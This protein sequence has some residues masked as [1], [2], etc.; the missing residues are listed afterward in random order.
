M[1][2]TRKTTDWLGREKEEHFDD[3]GDKVGETRFKEDW[4]GN[5]V[6]EHFNSQ[7]EKIAETRAGQDSLG[8]DRAEHFDVNHDRIGTS[9][10]E[11]DFTGNAIQRHYDKSGQRVGETRWKED[12][13]GRSI[14]QHEGEYFKTRS[15]NDGSNAAGNRYSNDHGSSPPQQPVKSSAFGKLIFVAIVML[16]IIVFALLRNEAVPGINAVRPVHVAERSPSPPSTPQIPIIRIRKIGGVIFSY[17]EQKWGGS[18]FGT[19]GIPYPDV[20]LQ[21]WSGLVSGY[22]VVNWKG[23][24]S[25]DQ[26]GL[27]LTISD[28]RIP[29]SSPTL[30]NYYS[31][32]GIGYDV[33]L[34]NATFGDRA[35]ARIP[36]LY[37]TFAGDSPQPV[38]TKCFAVTPIKETP[39]SG[40]Q[41]GGE[42][43]GEL[44]DGV[45]E[46]TSSQQQ[47]IVARVVQ[48]GNRFEGSM[49]TY[50][51]SD[52]GAQSK[53]KSK[54]EGWILK[55][56]VTF[57]KTDDKALVGV[58]YVAKISRDS[59][60][61]IGTTFAGLGKGTWHMTRMG[62]L[63]GDAD[64]FLGP[65]MSNPPSNN[66]E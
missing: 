65:E 26:N 14:K 22:A 28:L 34:E 35:M 15:V 38:I 36:I 1:G 8:R 31:D 41:M 60:D 18:A 49:L 56:S 32:F 40:F 42:W 12:Y 27:C 51:T 3:K 55:D 9:R 64:E 59:K 2:K 48:R 45:V 30:Q 6:Q 47:K 53:I 44:G 4:L 39:T 46:T 52:G 11:T 57:V 7:D 61:L 33:E 17:S 5:K 43:Q 37:R 54:V 29:K 23:S 20:A 25:F 16:L 66:Q 50:Q 62:D 58:S 19:G 13:L 63:V 21:F 10:N 24:Y